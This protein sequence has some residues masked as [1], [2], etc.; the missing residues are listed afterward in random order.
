MQMAGLPSSIVQQAAVV[1]RHL[2]QRVGS[3]HPGRQQQQ[4][5]ESLQQP[6]SS[7]VLRLCS[8]VL[9][10]LGATQQGRGLGS[11]ELMQLQQAASQQVAT[12]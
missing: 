11:D 10:A 1:A 2:K 7:D 5:Q 4:Q 3:P 9:Q 6:C 8:H 12:Q